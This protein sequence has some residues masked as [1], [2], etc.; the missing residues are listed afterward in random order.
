MKQPIDTAWQLYL[1]DVYNSQNESLATFG[2]HPTLG[3]EPKRDLHMIY[4]HKGIHFS[5]KNPIKPYSEHLFLSAADNYAMNYFNRVDRVIYPDY[6]FAEVTRVSSV[7]VS[8]Y[9]NIGHY[10]EGM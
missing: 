4:K 5:T 3:L 9:L 8:K 10:Y 7:C 1:N 6:A 2:K